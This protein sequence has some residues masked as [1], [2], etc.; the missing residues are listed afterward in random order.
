MHARGISVRVI[1]SR[2]TVHWYPPLLSDLD[3][4]C[5]LTCIASGG[6][7]QS[8]VAVP[9]SSLAASGISQVVALVST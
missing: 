8:G 5:L 2:L 7:R 1:F 4:L 6:F 9:E 3:V